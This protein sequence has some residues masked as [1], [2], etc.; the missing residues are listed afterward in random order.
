VLEEL[1]RA[2]VV[3]LATHA[4]FSGVDP[5]ASEIVLAD[6]SVTAR[7]ILQ[8]RVNAKLIVLSACETGQSA[9]MRGD[10]LAGM[11]Q[12][13]LQAGAR[14]LVASLW[15]VSDPATAELMTEFY[16]T[17][18][19]GADKAEALSLAAARM[20]ANAGTAHPFFWGAFMLIGDWR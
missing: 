11:S 14:T 3:H 20:R 7:E 15:R 19:R 12:A 10:E 18:D 16:R 2:D 8:Q 5:L 4:R 13:F 1:S 17:C 9:T 6:G